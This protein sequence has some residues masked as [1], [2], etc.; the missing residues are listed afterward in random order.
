M[1]A[2]NEQI[3]KTEADLAAGEAWRVVC[4]CSDTL[5]LANNTLVAGG[6]GKVV[7]F[8]KATGSTLWTGKVEGKARGLAVA[9]GRLLVSSNTGEIRCFGEEGSQAFGIVPQ[10]V[11]TTQFPANDMA[12]VCEA[13]ASHIVQTTGIKR[14]YCLMLGCGTG[15]LAYELTKRNRFVHSWD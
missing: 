2:L 11:D 10:P 12:Q 14:G 6:A 15:R 4:D 8:D 9:D 3:A 1:D 7:A 5:L 13:A